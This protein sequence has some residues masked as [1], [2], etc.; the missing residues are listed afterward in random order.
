[1]KTLATGAL[2]MKAPVTGARATGVLDMK[3]MITGV[4]ESTGAP[5]ASA[6]AQTNSGGRRRRR[7]GICHAGPRTP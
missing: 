6:S 4:R 7:C 5:S 1:M 3:A 2:T